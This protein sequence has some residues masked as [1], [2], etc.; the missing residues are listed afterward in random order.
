VVEHRTLDRGQ[1]RARRHAG[2]VSVLRVGH[3]SPRSLLNCE[4]EP[5]GPRYHLA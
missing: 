3:R 2:R 4:D 1:V 5:V